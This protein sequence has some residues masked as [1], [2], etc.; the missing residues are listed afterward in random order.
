MLPIYGIIGCGG[1]AKFHLEGLK[2]AGANV[3]CVSDV[4]EQAA[5]PYVNEFGAKY[6]PDYRRM[7]TDPDITAV[8]VLASGKLHR[9]MCI[10]ALNAGKDVI[11]EKTMTNGVAEAAQ[12]MKAV[13]ESGRIFFTA[14]MKRFFPATQKALELLPSIGR[15]FSAH[16]RSYQPW[17]EDYFTMESASD[18]DFSQVYASYG[19]AILKCAGS[20]MLDLMMCF[21]GR[22]QAVSANMDYIKGTRFDRKASALFD[23]KEGATALFEAAAHPYGKIGYERNGWDEQMEINGSRGKLLINTVLWDHPENNG[24]LLVHYDNE[25]ATSTEYRFDAVNPFDIETVY[26]KNCLEDRNQGN[27]DVIDGFNVDAVIETMVQSACEKQRIEIDWD[28][29]EKLHLKEN[30]ENA[31]T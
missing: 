26:Y 21:M 20:H 28:A 10:E 19:G 5:L 31:Y 22:P 3:A 13:Q 27:P 24:A 9:Q 29:L 7:I 14:Y 25:S 8:Y 2:K 23:F 6:Y 30:Q 1:I 18:S 15:V 16:I 11:C 12:V 17:K 4:D